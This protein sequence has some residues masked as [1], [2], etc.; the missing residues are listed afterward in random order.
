MFPVKIRI[1]ICTVIEHF[2]QILKE[3]GVTKK[4]KV[5]IACSGGVDSMT[6][7]YLFQQ[8]HASIAVAH[9]N[10]QLRTEAE[11]E[12]E[13]VQNYCASNQIKCFIQNFD[14]KEYATKQKVSTQMAARKLRYRWFEQVMNEE[15]FDFLATAHHANDNVETILLN[16]TKGT[17]IRGLSGIAPKNG[18]L[19]RPL[20]SFKKESLHEFASQHRI[21]YKD[22]ESNFEDDYQRNFIR[23]QIIPR[24]QEIN[25]NMVDSVTRNMNQVRFAKSCYDNRIETILKKIV[26]QDGRYEVVFV[27]QLLNFESPFTILYEFL[28][29]KQFSKSDCRH[30]YQWMNTH[31]NESSAVYESPTH[32]ASIDNRNRLL[33]SEVQSKTVLTSIEVD[34]REVTVNGKI[35]STNRLLGNQV[36]YELGNNQLQ[37]DAEK[38]TYPLQIR[39]WAPGDYFYPLGLGKKQKVSK[40]LINEKV[41]KQEKENVYV[42][43]SSE[44][45]VWLIGYRGDDRFKVSP[46][47]KTMVHFTI[48]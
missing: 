8:V 34:Q 46:N 13:L 14:T 32:K 22:D 17:G 4:S 7:L 16:F 15:Q 28:K 12:T 33:I 36:F 24:L 9:C 47:T 42:I 48:H 30:L 19:I 27:K 35:L 21:P 18:S 1:Y 40:F 45:I 2:K 3:F 39:K 31:T 37:V 25:P 43:T 5:L 6:L 11:Q 41:H 38:L 10:F 20:L 26:H 23:N 44:K 29:P